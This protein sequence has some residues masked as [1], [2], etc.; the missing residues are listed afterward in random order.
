[1]KGSLNVDKDQHHWCGQRRLSLGLVR[2]LCLTPA[3]SGSEV[4]LMDVSPERL[5]AIQTSATGTSRRLGATIRAE[6]TV[7]RG[8]SLKDADFRDQ[9][10]ADRRLWNG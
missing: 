8:A 5:R 2:D 10:R 3:L 7:D 1:M 6:A 4:S 9:Y